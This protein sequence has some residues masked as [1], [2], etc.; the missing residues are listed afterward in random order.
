MNLL[1]LLLLLLCIRG[2]SKFVLL[3]KWFYVDFAFFYI[4]G[5]GKLILPVPSPSHYHSNMHSQCGETLL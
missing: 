4:K 2:G 3:F 5:L 1:L